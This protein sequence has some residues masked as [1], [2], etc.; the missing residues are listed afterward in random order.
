MQLSLDAIMPGDL[1]ARGQG[2]QVSERELHRPFD[3]AADFELP[4]LEAALAQRDI[5]GI[6][7]I[8]RAVRLEI[9]RDLAGRVFWR[10]RRFGPEQRALNRLGHR[11]GFVENIERLRRARIEAT[12]RKRRGRG[13]DP[14]AN[15]KLAARESRLRRADE[16][17]AAHR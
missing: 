1:R 17:L 8:D 14:E 4:I 13:A 7:G 10:K 12:G 3:K 2:A 9:G 15:E 11:L 16:F 5:S 6:L